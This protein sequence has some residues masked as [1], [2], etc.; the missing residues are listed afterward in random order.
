M[1]VYCD[2]VVTAEDAGRPRNTLSYDYLRDICAHE[3]RVNVYTGQI[4]H[5]LPDGKAFEHNIQ[6]IS[7]AN[8]N[9]KSHHGGTMRSLLLA[10]LILLYT[11]F[12]CASSLVLVV[13][14]TRSSSLWAYFA[15]QPCM[16][17]KTQDFSAFKHTHCGKD[18]GVATIATTTTKRSC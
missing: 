13:G 1:A 10:L 12:I 15:G 16:L 18:M 2:F 5:V 14:S 8:I 7:V 6:S 4:T 11:V 3:N 17:L 9:Q